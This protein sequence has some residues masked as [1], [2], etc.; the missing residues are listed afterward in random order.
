M[1]IK[2]QNDVG[3][4]ANATPSQITQI[5]ADLGITSDIAAAVASRVTIVNA[6]T[7]VTVTGTS[8]NPIVNAILDYADLTDATTADLPTVNI[9]LNTALDGK[10]DVLGVGG[11]ITGTGSL[12]HTAH[13]NRQVPI[14]GA[15]GYTLSINLDST[16]SWV[17][18]DCLELVNSTSGVITISGGTA[19]L[20]VPT[21]YKA[22]INPNEVFYALRTGTNTWSSTTFSS[23]TPVLIQMACSDETTA[24]TTGTGKVVFRAPYAFTLTAV[25]ASVTTAPTGGTLLTVDV[26]E[27]GT[28]LLS[29]K[30]TFDAS[31]KTTTTAAT[32]AVISDSAIAD[33]AEISVDIDA[34]GSTI[35]GAGLKVTLIGTKP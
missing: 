8:T 29:T 16:G 28:T 15:G 13:A 10:V 20:N 14:T 26:N 11:A 7:N 4:I 32:P 35:A 23:V 33:D 34:V 24:L 22:T 19:T 17:S 6:G 12:N 2:L 31:E 1:T 21:G 5:K 9:P 25:R 3:V 27:S 30:L 18:D